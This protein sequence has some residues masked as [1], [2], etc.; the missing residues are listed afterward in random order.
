MVS[1]YLLVVDLSPENAEEINSLLRNSGIIVH[2]LFADNLADAERQ[3]EEHSPFLVIFN[4]TAAVDV[5]VAHLCGLAAKR[6]F[7]LAVRFTPSAPEVLLEALSEYA[8]LG[9]NAES[10]EQLTAVVERQLS[11][12]N[13]AR[14]YDD[15]QQNT[16]ELQ[17]RYNLLFNS[18]RDA[19]AYI[20]EG[21]HIFA[22]GA[23]LEAMQVKDFSELESLSLLELM[24]GDEGNLKK[25]IRNI[26]KGKFPADPVAVTV[27]TPSGTEFQAKLAFS[28]ARFNSEDCIQ[29]ILEQQDSHAIL[30]QELKRVKRMDPLTELANRQVFR[31]QLAARLERGLGQVAGAVYYLEPDDPQRLFLDLGM[32]GMDSLIIALSERICAHLEDEDL[33][34]RFSDHG[35]CVF[36]LRDDKSKL[37][38]LGESLKTAVSSGELDINDHV[39]TIACSIG[40]TLLGRQSRSAEEV[41]SQARLAWD[42]AAQQG[43]SVATYKP[44]LKSI[45]SGEQDDLW[46]ERIRYALNNDT[47][48]SVQQA[49]VNLEGDSEGLFENRTFM[50]E[51]EGDRSLEEF[52]RVAERHELASTI[53]RQVI[54]GLLR[55]IKGSGDQHIINLSSN[56]VLDFSF[57]SWFQRQLEELDV[58]GSQVVLQ[59]SSQAAQANLKPTRRLMQEFKPLGLRFSLSS[60]DD[61]RRTCDLLGQLGI[62]MVKLRKGLTQSL[63]NNSAHQDI[64]RNVVSVAERANAAVIADEVRN[65]A[66]MAALWQCGVKLVAGD[67]LNETP[68]VVGQ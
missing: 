29:M 25:V 27:N 56:S 14:E 7:N 55:A 15:M 67:F 46:L 66:D 17:D 8:C 23:Y 6:Q 31:D 5:S 39:F 44:A 18:A 53:D 50:R 52:L 28:P 36:A 38:E 59:L 30:K 64:I 48:Y 54:P 20:H 33:V 61:Q 45:D 41:I 10:D 37:W 22:N 13:S 57:P 26:G 32:S 49:I 62:S 43:D 60:F 47:L 21:L 34:S 40:Q 3:V 12:G 16:Q 1:A 24:I 35:F 42:D 68:Q 9:I 2:T 58:Q 63:G 11:L 4:D 51:E 65:T 19:I